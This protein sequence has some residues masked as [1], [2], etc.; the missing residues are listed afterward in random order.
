MKLAII[1]E[2]M[3]SPGGGDRLLLSV[4]KAFPDADVYTSVFVAENYNF[5]DGASFSNVKPILKSS[6]FLVLML[7]SRLFS[8]FT[9]KTINLIS[10]YLYE[11]LDLRQYDRFLSLSARNA[12][13]VITT[14]NCTHYNLFLTPP[15]YEWD[16][17]TNLRM[18]HSKGLFGFITQLFS[19]GFRQWDYVSSSRPDVN[20]AIS[21][22]I[23]A[24]VKKIYGIECEV[25]YPGIS[26]SAFDYSE[27]DAGNSAANS[28]TRDKYF[29]VVSRLYDYKH[30]EMAIKACRLS[31]A[32][33][34]I[35]GEGP[36]LHFLEA[37]AQNDPKIS[38]LGNVSD[39]L[40]KRY[41]RNAEALLFCGVEDFGLVM[42][43]AMA[44]GCPV[45]GLNEGGA[46]E[47]VTSDTG[48]LY[49]EFDEL[50]SIV[51]TFKKSKFNEGDIISRAKSFSEE[52]FVKNLKNV[53]K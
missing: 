35:I 19:T 51:S 37:V 27:G 39:S 30:I 38:F 49:N 11:N 52:I 5:W 7:K 45:I 14:M 17:N 8:R 42:V 6:K 16:K 15:R 21:K 28:G 24:K 4:L 43:E 9:Q 44:Q 10:P 13:S 53:I 25:I 1:A 50:V 34:A 20:F 22:Y 29:L 23:A 18:F 2:Q 33:L 3:I 32:K 48:V 41:F 47:I 12:K 40:M 46:A 26:E 31:H 36:D